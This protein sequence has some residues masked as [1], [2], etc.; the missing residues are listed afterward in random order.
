MLLHFYVFFHG[1]LPPSQVYILFPTISRII[2]RQR[3]LCGL[4]CDL[5][6]YFKT[7]SIVGEPY[8]KKK[9]KHGRGSETTVSHKNWFAQKRPH[10]GELMWISSSNLLS[11]IN[12]STNNIM[13]HYST[14]E[15]K[16]M[17]Q[18]SQVS[19]SISAELCCHMPWQPSFICDCYDHYTLNALFKQ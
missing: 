17:A 10:K 12:M 18:V 16:V 19:T 8:K 2:E 14:S 7:K 6:T 11:Y 5:H 3:A 13:P 4:N 1:H 15:W 9:K